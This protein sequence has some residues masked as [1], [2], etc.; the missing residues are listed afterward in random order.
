MKT[1]KYQKIVNIIQEYARLYNYNFALEESIEDE[2]AKYFVL[3]KDKICFFTKMC[4][5]DNLLAEH[6]SMMINIFKELGLDPIVSMK[7]NISLQEYLDYLDVDYETNNNAGEI[8]CTY[9]NQNMILG[10]TDTNKS[11]V[12]SYIDIKSLTSQ[13]ADIT[14]DSIDV[15][16]KAS[17]KEE[18][19]KA[20]ILI[21]DLRLSG[22][23][24]DTNYLADYEINARNI[25]I[26]SDEDLK[27]GLILVKDNLTQEETKIPEDEIIEYMLG[28]I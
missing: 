18:K 27:K 7:E 28:V 1:K 15:F 11:Q 9:L 19:L 2:F 5:S 16:I 8:I 4:I 10:Y 25:I 3:A 6:I 17:S 20:N 22:V 13:M 14:E 12:I 26:L 21:N 24:C 23:V